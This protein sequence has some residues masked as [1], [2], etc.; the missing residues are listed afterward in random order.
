M[1]SYG[2]NGGPHVFKAKKYLE[3]LIAKAEDNGLFI[4]YHIDELMNITYELLE[5]NHLIN[6]TIV[7]IIYL[8]D[9]ETHFMISAKKAAPFTVRENLQLDEDLYSS[10]LNIS[11]S[12]Q[13]N[14]CSENPFFFIK[15]GILYTPKVKEKE[16]TGIIRDTI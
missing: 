10:I 15:D 9:G 1:R 12:G 8:K 6:A 7:P 2:Y 3:L 4:N 5:K 16:P 13:I 14:F 11:S